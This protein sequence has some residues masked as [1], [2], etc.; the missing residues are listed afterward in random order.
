MSGGSELDAP[1]PGDGS[2]GS[3]G[4]QERRRAGG[5][6]KKSPPG[7][8]TVRR[9]QGEIGTRIAYFWSTFGSGVRMS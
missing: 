1:H 3:H 8:G 4:N 6:K 7:Q 5:E 9:A 2:H